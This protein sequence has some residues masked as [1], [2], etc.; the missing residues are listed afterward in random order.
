MDRGAGDGGGGNAGRRR[1][2]PRGGAVVANG[3]IRAGDRDVFK[4]F[5]GYRPSF[6][7]WLNSETLV[8]FET[9]DDAA[10]A[11]NAIGRPIPSAPGVPSVPAVWREAERPLV[12]GKS[13]KWARKREVE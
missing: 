3:Y 9:A 10:R 5:D 7:E 12:K 2:P 1:R 11:L 8:V 13:D 4:L 6:V